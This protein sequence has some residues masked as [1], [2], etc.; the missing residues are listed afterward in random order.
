MKKLLLLSVMTV[1]GLAVFLAVPFNS[2]AQVVPGPVAHWKFDNN[3]FESVSGVTTGS[4]GTISYSTDT[5]PIV[6]NTTSIFL[7]GTNTSSDGYLAT[8]LRLFNGW[9]STTVSTWIKL[10]TTTVAGWSNNSCNHELLFKYRV[11]HLRLCK[12]SGQVKL[13]STHSN[14]TPFGTRLQSTGNIPTNTWVHLA[15]VH[16][17]NTITQYING[18]VAGTNT[19][20]KVLGGTSSDSTTISGHSG[21]LNSFLDDLRIYNRVLTASEIQQLYGGTGTPVTTYNITSSA[22]A[23]GTISPLGTTVVNQGASQTYTITPNSG[24]QIS[25]VLVNGTNVG[26]LSS[27]TFSNVGAHQTISATFTQIPPTTFTITASSGTNGTITPSGNVTVASG[28]NHTFTI[29]PNTGYQIANVLVNGAS[30]GTVSSYTFTN[31]TSNKTISATFSQI[32][33]PPVDG[34]FEINNSY[35][36]GLVNPTAM[37]FAPDGRL[38]VAEQGGTVRI[39]TSDGVLLGTPFITIPGVYNDQERGLLGITFDPNFASNGYVYLFHTA[40]G[41]T[42]VLMRVTANGDVSVPGSEVTLLSYDNFSGNHRGGDIHFGPDGKLYLALGEA[43]EPTNSQLVNTFN[44]KMLR[45]NPDGTIPADNPT[46]F[47][48]TAGVSTT[49]SGQYRAIWAIGLRNPYR[50]SFHPVTGQM[51]IND[52]GAGLWEEINIGQAGKNYGWPTCEGLC[53]NSFAENPIHVHDRNQPDACAITGGTF[54]TGNQFPSTYKNSYLFIDYC[55]T[56]IRRLQTDMTEATV[57]VTIPMF[58]ADIKEDLA[59][60]IYVAGNG[61]GTIS[62]IT[63]VAT[64]ANHVPSAHL[65]TSTTTGPSPLTVSFDARATTDQDNDPLTF[66]WNF[67]DTTT[68]TGATTSH[69]YTSSGTFN[70]VLTVTDGRGGTSTAPVTISVGTPPVASI[71]TPVAGSQ[72]TAGDTITFSGSATDADDGILPASS[73][74]W[75]ILF[76]HNTHIHP[77]IGPINGTTTGSFTIPTIGHTEENVWYRIYLTV[78]DSSGVQT[79]V[80]RDVLPRKTSVTLDSNIPGAQ[81]LLDGSPFTSPYTFIGVSGVQRTIEVVSPQTINGQAYEFVSWSDGGARS[82]GISTPL[83]TTTYTATFAVAQIPTF[84]IVS[85]AGDNGVI[86]PL[87]TTTVNQG[88]SQT[89]TVVPDTGYQVQSVIVNGTSAT[90][91]NNTYTFTNVTS[92]QTMSVTFTQIPVGPIPNLTANW[93]FDNNL[94]ES[95]SG[96]GS[97]GRGTIAYTTDVAPISGST[98]SLSSVGTGGANDTNIASGLPLF[99]SWTEG[100]ASLWIKVTAATV[101]SWA[102]GSQHTLLNKHNV[103][104]MYLVKDTSGVKVSA[105]HGDATAMGSLITS[106]SNIPTDRWVHISSVH[107]GTTITLYIDG[108]AVGSG[109]TGRQLGAP[110]SDVFSISEY[111]GGYAGLLDDLRLYNRALTASEIQRLNQ[112]Q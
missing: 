112:G 43:G 104:D 38:F 102:N 13:E 71:D 12:V 61:S 110:S 83:A 45:L 10:S 88:G 107:N 3:T 79:Q 93:R 7:R 11:I 9:S 77:F 85:S 100:T 99:T 2:E 53:T 40:N 80:T 78:T 39:I 1:F 26:A 22:G 56:W 58:S 60:N 25:Q 49:T 67:G 55:G 105:R 34:S 18:Q 16:N 91:T 6:G 95:I 74:S 52:V 98:A 51:Y 66:T 90:L 106:T 48:T 111:A 32:P 35:A 103:I 82:H 84:T 19:I 97:S 23:N 70:A 87:G 69:T 59:G 47:T 109:N 21:Y 41:G 17:G 96:S 36:T 72:Y 33:P 89:Y 57:P 81:I 31:V 27:Y 54:Y 62:K 28:S 37:A 76:H 101:N 73:Y 68:G 46:T 108:I 29:T 30:V 64:H 75:T 94:V 92:N 4:F 24:Y 20:N 15:S 86:T 65:T 5:A 42:S 14:A 8:S 50:F 44:G 63:F